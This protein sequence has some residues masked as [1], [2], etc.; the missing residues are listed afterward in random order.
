MTFK[1]YLPEKIKE[2]IEDYK[3]LILSFSILTI[4]LAYAVYITFK[5]TYEEIEEIQTLKKEYI[6]KEGGGLV[7]GKT[8]K[9]GTVI[10]VKD[11]LLFIKDEKLYYLSEKGDSVRVIKGKFIIKNIK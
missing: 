2:W 4:M 8:M 5:K 6:E 7:V 3:G 10:K 1:K 9:R 11:S